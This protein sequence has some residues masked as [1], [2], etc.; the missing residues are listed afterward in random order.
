MKGAQSKPNPSPNAFPK[1]CEWF[2]G[3]FLLKGR[4]T[5]TVPSLRGKSSWNLPNREIKRKERLITKIMCNNYEQ[6]LLQAIMSRNYYRQLWGEINTE[7]YQLVINHAENVRFIGI[8]AYPKTLTVLFVMLEESLTWLVSVRKPRLCLK[9]SYLLP[10]F[11]LTNFPSF[12]PLLLLSNTS[13][14]CLFNKYINVF[15]FNISH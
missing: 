15:L 6:K 13:Y 4:G 14:S 7:N 3:R 11:L 10:D 5:R 2:S 9:I 1:L 8:L 12:A